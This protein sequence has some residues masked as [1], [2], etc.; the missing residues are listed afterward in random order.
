MKPHYFNKAVCS[1]LLISALPFCA[2][3]SH[4][5]AIATVHNAIVPPIVKYSGVLTDDGGKALTTMVGVTFSL[6]REA[7]GGAALWMETQNVLPDDTGRYSV[8]LGSTTNAG[9]PFF[10]FATGEAHWLGI[11]VQGQGEQP[12][13]LLLSV[14]YSLKAADADTLGGL[15]ASAFVQRAGN[16]ASSEADSMFSAAGNNTAP[17]SPTLTK[18]YIPVLTGSTPE[19][20][21]SIMYQAG[22]N[23]IGINTTSPVATLEVNG[24]GQFDGATTFKGTQTVNAQANFAANN[25]SQVVQVTQ[26]GS[27]A[28][29]LANTS[30]ASQNAVLGNITAT[31][32]TFA[33]IKGTSAS[34]SGKGVDGSSN[35]LGVVG[36][37]FGNS[38]TGDSS[39][40]NAGVWGDTGGASNGGFVGVLGTADEN[41]AGFF[42]NNSSLAVSLYLQNNA[43]SQADALVLQTFGSTYKGICTIDVSGNLTCSGSIEESVPVDSGARNVAFYSLQSTENW[44]EDAGSGKLSGGSATVVLD[45]TFLQTISG[46]VDY[47]VFLTPTG[48]SRGLFV[49]NKTPGSFE[50]R[51]Q[52]GGTS[53]I[54]FDYRIMAKRKGFENRRLA[55]I[56]RHPNQF[57]ARPAVAGSQQPSHSR[58]QP[59]SPTNK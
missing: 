15:P 47:R 24:S 12:R 58:P 6:Y 1:V 52:G 35:N 21:N 10:L 30:S 59:V 14:P 23:S 54:A 8:M 43:K 16:A 57:R 32:G 18:N 48:D 38:N 11:Q 36:E 37:S 29:I 27:G 17:K 4:A 20:T 13:V 53:N 51:E 49:T 46:S 3:P 19:A 41:T 22:G 50:V 33:A 55:E 2:V 40:L 56:T 45:P 7:Q 31:S 26:S 5:Q 28:A 25:S 42:M 9:L 39:G 34:P 44:F